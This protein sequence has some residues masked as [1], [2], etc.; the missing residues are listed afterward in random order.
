[1]AAT[2]V[3]LLN[4]GI[5]GIQGGSEMVKRYNASAEY[6]AAGAYVEI[7]E[8]DDG[9]FVD[10]HDYAALQAENERLKALEDAFAEAKQLS[11]D[12]APQ[13]QVAYNWIEDRAR[14]IARKVPALIDAHKV[15]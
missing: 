10:H 1:M 3:M 5:D 15:E 13:Y 8:A 6:D 11:A 4:C 7:Y 14:E 12:R 2:R 9:R